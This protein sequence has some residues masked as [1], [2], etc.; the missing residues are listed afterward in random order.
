MTDV[1][2]VVTVDYENNNAGQIKKITV[3]KGNTVIG[4]YE[5]S[6]YANGN[7]KDKKEIVNGGELKTTEYEY[8][9]SGHLVTEN[10]G[11]TSMTY[12]YD[13]SGNRSSMEVTGVSQPYTTSYT[14]DKNNRMTKESKIYSSGENREETEYYYDPN[15]NMISKAKGEWKTTTGIMSFSMLP[16]TTKGSGVYEYNGFNQLVSLYDSATNSNCSYTYDADGLRQSKTVNGVTTNHIWDGMNMVA[17]TDGNNAVKSVYTRGRELI[18]SKN[19]MEFTYY[20]H[21][22]HGDVNMLMN[23]NGSI[24]KTYNY[25]AFGVEQD[26]V[27]NDTNPFRYCGEYYDK[28]TDNIYLRARYYAPLQG[29]FTTEDPA[30]DGLNWYSYCGGNPVAFADPSGLGTI[31]S[32]S[33]DFIYNDVQYRINEASVDVG[34]INKSEQLTVDINTDYVSILSYIK[35]SGDADSKPVF[36]STGNRHKEIVV[37]EV[38]KF[39]SGI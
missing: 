31:V 39:W 22:G 20:L 4:Q 37:R 1:L 9:G 17:E 28:E 13:R 11:S 24:T 26:K 5:Y 34:V 19:G 18:S 10:R 8:D 15:G 12:E 25:D 14:Y 3:K 21:N 30:E 7:M 29:R 35:F 36:S 32:G 23:E 27:S 2:A 38:Q 16:S 33:V 6:Y